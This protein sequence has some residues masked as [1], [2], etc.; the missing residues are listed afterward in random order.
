MT[1]DGMVVVCVDTA[2]LWKLTF[3]SPAL[4]RYCANCCWQAV[5]KLSTRKVV[6]VRLHNNM[7]VKSCGLVGDRRVPIILAKLSFSFDGIWCVV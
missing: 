4:R 5:R 3:V 7:M 6:S 2:K 1:K